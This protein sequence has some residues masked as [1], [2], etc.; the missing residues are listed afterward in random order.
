MNIN[1][2][3]V[4]SRQSPACMAPH[5]HSPGTDVQAPGCHQ[6]HTHPSGHGNPCMHAP[7]HQDESAMKSTMRAQLTW[8]RG[9][10]LAAGPLPMVKHWLRSA[11][12]G[13]PPQWME[14]SHNPAG[15]HAS[16][17]LRIFLPGKPMLASSDARIIFGMSTIS[18]L[19]HESQPAVGLVNGAVEGGKRVPGLQSQ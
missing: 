13:R 18:G 7:H 15:P 3:P 16:A 8:C 4:Q 10:L 2:A 12:C 9:T 1:G 14:T 11:H 5:P 17:G 6:S 19:L